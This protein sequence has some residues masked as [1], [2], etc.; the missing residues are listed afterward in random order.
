MPRKQIPS[1]SWKIPSG[2][3]LATQFSTEAYVVTILE[4]RVHMKERGAFK[5]SLLGEALVKN[6]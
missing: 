2:S 5:W 1:I 4:R 3:R 6:A